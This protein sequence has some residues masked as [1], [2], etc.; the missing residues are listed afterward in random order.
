MQQS[1]NDS[2]T[3]TP[4][5]LATRNCPKC[6]KPTATKYCG[7]CGSYV[8]EA[9]PVAAYPNPAAPQP[10]PVYPYSPP[11]AANVSHNGAFGSIL[12]GLAGLFIVWDFSVLFGLI[13]GLVAVYWGF[14]TVK[15]KDTWGAI[16]IVLG[17]I[18][19]VLAI[20]VF[21]LP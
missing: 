13:L 18:S 20:L 4:Q 10:V 5:A 14:N 6:G 11:P 7:R 8:P 21:V 16:A 19:V 3:N 12:V 9:T 15:K 17:L 1:P 2:Y